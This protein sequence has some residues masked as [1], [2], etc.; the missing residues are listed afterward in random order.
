MNWL[1]MHLTLRELFSASIGLLLT[2][3]LSVPGYAETDD[4]PASTEPVQIKPVQIQPVQAVTFTAPF[5]TDRQQALVMQLNHPNYAEREH[6]TGQLKMDDTIDET[7]LAKALLEVDDL[8]HEQWHRLLDVAEFRIKHLQ[9]VRIV[10][11]PRGQLIVPAAAVGINYTILAEQEASDE[12]ARFRVGQVIEGM[13]AAIWVKPGDLILACDGEAFPPDMQQ[14]GLGVRIQRKLNGE[15][16][17][18]GE[19]IVLTLMRHGKVFDVTISTMDAIYLPPQDR[20]QAQLRNNQLN[21]RWQRFRS[22][23]IEAMAQD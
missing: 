18:P 10:N 7:W 1:D 5:M 9:L 11:Q 16:R 2:A 12:Q 8:T 13:K 17:K 14:R 15:V 6:A 21:E 20:N 19:S 22:R 3:V 23:L 4:E